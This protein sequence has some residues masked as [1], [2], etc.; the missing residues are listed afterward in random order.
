MP[1][2][3]TL[4]AVATT[5]S[6]T[7]A[8]AAAQ[9]Q[10]AS[11]TSQTPDE[12][13]EDWQLVVGSADVTGVGPQI[14]TVMSP[15]ANLS[16]PFV[17]YD[18][19]YREYPSFQPGGMQLQVWTDN[20]VTTT[21]SQESDQFQTDNETVTWTQKIKISSGSIKCSVA[22]G[23]S[24]TWGRFGQSDDNNFNVSYSTGLTSLSGYDP[25][26]SVKN[27]GASWESDR[28]TTLKLIQVRYYSNG[29]LYYTDTTTRNLIGN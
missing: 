13:Q 24:T 29:N 16:D 20:K 10:D 8:L 15:T 5:A 26:F 21:S 11:P 27:S 1:F 17:A 18:M 7:L 25:A 22:N 23:Q 28:V 14:T 2:S 12:I 6:L 9:A 4:I 3:R 19:N